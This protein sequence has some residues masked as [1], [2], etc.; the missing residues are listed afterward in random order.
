MSEKC[1]NLKVG[2]MLF[3]IKSNETILECA[4]RNGMSINYKCASGYCGKCRTR[5]LNGRVRL[6]H[7]GGISRRNIARGFVL[8]CCTFPKSDIE[9]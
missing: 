6:E 9:I 4:Y 5:L 2:G 7:S 1:F 8:V 3:E